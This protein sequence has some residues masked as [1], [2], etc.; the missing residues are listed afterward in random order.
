MGASCL[1]YSTVP[2]FL[3]MLISSSPGIAASQDLSANDIPKIITT[4]YE[5]E[6]EFKHDYLGKTFAATMFFK[7]VREKALVTGY[8]VGFDG[9]NGSAG[10]A[11][12]FSESPTGEFIDW[13]VGKSVSL[14]GVVSDVALAALYLEGCEFE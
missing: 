7:S 13:D 6:Q 12:S 4:Y 10:L 8:Y 11:C 14:T 9:K 5:N 1:K 3:I 2:I